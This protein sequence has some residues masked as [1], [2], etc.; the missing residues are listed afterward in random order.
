VP[1]VEPVPRDS[2][3]EA[4]AAA[5]R[6]VVSEWSAV[7]ALGRLTDLATDALGALPLGAAGEGALDLLGR[8]PSES[9]GDSAEK[10]RLSAPDW[11][12]AALAVVLLEGLRRD[13]ASPCAGVEQRRRSSLT[14]T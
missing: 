10:G 6:Q 7:G 8:P 2:S 9:D 4:H 3:R 12:G 5:V 14:V 13:A 11:F 1:E